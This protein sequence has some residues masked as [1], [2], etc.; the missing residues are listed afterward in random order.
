LRL[1]LPL[2]LVA[3]L[4]EPEGNPRAACRD[5][6]AQMTP[7]AK[8]MKI[9]LTH[10]TLRVCF[11]SPPVFLFTTQLVGVKERLASL[12]FVLVVFLDAVE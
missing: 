7:T 9:P 11:Q 6:R 10:V 8:K 2:P 5:E 1:L 12:I 4:C 3:D